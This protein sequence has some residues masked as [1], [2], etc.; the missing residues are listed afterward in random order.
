MTCTSTATTSTSVTAS[1]DTWP[2][3]SQA[4][5]D[6]TSTGLTATSNERGRIATPQARSEPGRTA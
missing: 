5:A 6:P 4:S 1:H 3:R 2:V